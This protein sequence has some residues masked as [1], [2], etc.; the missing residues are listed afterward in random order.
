MTAT[1]KGAVRR[2]VDTG[3]DRDALLYDFGIDSPILGSEH[4]KYLDELIVFLSVPGRPPMT[5]SMD[6]FASRTGTAAHN[7]ELSEHRERVV[8]NYLRSHTSVFNPGNPHTLNRKFNGFTGSPPG[9]NP[10]FRSVRVVVHKP[11]VVPPPIPVTPT[12]TPAIVGKFAI[13]LIGWIPQPEVDNPLSVLPGAVTSLLPPG[14]ADPFFGGD[15]FTTPATAPSGMVPPSHTFRATQHIEFTISSWGLAPTVGSVA[16]TP[17][18]T[19]CLDK[20]R[21]AGG[22]VTFSLTATV[23][24][25]SATVTFSPLHDWYEITLSGVVMDP[26][27]PAA[28]AALTRKL[29]GVPALLRGPLSAAIAK[30]A[31]MA[32]P[33][34]SWDATVRIQHGSKLGTF[35][36]ATYAPFIGSEDSRLL[37]GATSALSPGSD[38]IHG[39]IHFSEWPSAVIFISFT[40]PGA[41]VSR[42]P[43]FF[44]S[45]MGLPRPEPAFIEVPLLAKLRQVTW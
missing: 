16:T 44:S 24:S 38:L 14:M 3:T 6:G 43:I 22:T 7:Q 12:P 1:T 9:E 2:D 4:T 26:V 29:P 28:A 8:E 34:L 18:T 31:T 11:G 45:G 13:D 25:S 20:R 32:T 41:A 40:P 35:A 19:T 10:L 15:N 5:V 23:L 42:Q 17:G 21:A 27:P 37:S 33:A 30:I 36:V 39:R